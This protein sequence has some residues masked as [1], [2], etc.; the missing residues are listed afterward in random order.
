MANKSA[1]KKRLKRKARQKELLKHKTHALREDK[2]SFC[3]EEMQY[4]RDRKAYGEALACL[5]KAMRIDPGDD[6]LVFDKA[7][8][9][10]RTTTRRPWM[11]SES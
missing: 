9:A 6:K 5:N 4:H 10:W 7:S 2:K 8:P 1:E 11:R 3:L